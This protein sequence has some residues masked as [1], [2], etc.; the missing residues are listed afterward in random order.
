MND[1]WAMPPRPVRRDRGISG[2]HSA[3][4]NS[5]QWLTPPEIIAALG[6]FDLDPCAA[7]EPRPWPTAARHV[8]LPENGL[9]IPWHGR[10]W[11]NPPYSR[12]VGRW[13]GRLAAHGCGTALVF[14]RTETSWFVDSVWYHADAALFLHGRVHFYR[15]SGRRARA[16][17]GGPSVLVAYGAYDAQRLAACGVPGTFIRGWQAAPSG[18][19]Q[20]AFE[21]D[22]Y[23]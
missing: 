15:P 2:H 3:Q 23:A 9:A 14:A 1:G 5:D 16:N 10:V 17:S 7:P 21:G 8:A 12:E 20:I 6:P 4:M 18:V 13:L 11:L 19:D 22:G